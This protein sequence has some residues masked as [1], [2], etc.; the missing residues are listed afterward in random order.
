V[1][2]ND[3]AYAPKLFRC[4][5][6]SPDGKHLAAAGQEGVVQLYDTATGADALTLKKVWDTQTGK[7]LLHWAGHKTAVWCAV[8][9]PTGKVLATVGADGTVR[10]WAADTG[11]ELCV[12]EK[13]T[14]AV[15][16]VAFSPDGKRLATAGADQAVRVWDVVGGGTGGA[17]RAR[18]EA[19]RRGLLPGRPAAGD[20][21]QRRTAAA[22]GR[23]RAGPGGG[24]LI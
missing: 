11:K 19:G 5:R 24:A 15:Q 16:C 6:F 21:G 10:L 23:N 18:P 12:I 1:W 20:H 3:G 17:P 4:V 8:F 14:H 2:G 22:V 13:Q 7:E 9:N